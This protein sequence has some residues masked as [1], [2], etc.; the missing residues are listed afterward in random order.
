MK[1]SYIV[2]FRTF[3]VILYYKLDISTFYESLSSLFYLCKKSKHDQTSDLS[4]YLALVHTLR[5]IL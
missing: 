3:S 2:S 1:Y 4:V 5:H